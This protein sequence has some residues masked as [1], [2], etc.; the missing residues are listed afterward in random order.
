[1][2]EN[3]DE[4]TVVNILKN[5]RCD[6]PQHP[7]GGSLLAGIYKIHDGILYHNNELKIAV[8]LRPNRVGLSIDFFEILPDDKFKFIDRRSIPLTE[9]VEGEL[10]RIIQVCKILQ[11]KGTDNSTDSFYG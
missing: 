7:V 10:M 4:T 3:M 8:G 2:D 5:K 6:D 9:E 11:K 1:M